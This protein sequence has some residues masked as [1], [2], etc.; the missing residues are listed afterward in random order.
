[1]PSHQ[2]EWRQTSWPAGVPLIAAVC[3]TLAPSSRW[4][5]RGALPSRHP[6]DHEGG[7]VRPVPEVDEGTTDDI[8]YAPAIL[9]TIDYLF[10]PEA[11]GKEVGARS[12]RTTL[13]SADSPIF[14]C[15]RSSQSCL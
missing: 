9:R 8:P 14:G 15:H 5:R 4:P 12:G 11:D 6:R 1:M 13:S 10:F 7:Q 2:G 3:V